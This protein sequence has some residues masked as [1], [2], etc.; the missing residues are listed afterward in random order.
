MDKAIASNLRDQ[1]QRAQ[2]RQEHG[3]ETPAKETTLTN[4]S[5]VGL[6]LKRSDPRKGRIYFRNRFGEGKFRAF[7]HQHGQVKLAGRM[8][9]WGRCRTTTVFRDEQ[10]DVV[11]PEE[12]EFGFHGKRPARLHEAGVRPRLYKLGRGDG[13]DH[14]AGAEAAPEGVKL[15]DAGREEHGVRML[16]EPCGSSG[17]IGDGNP[18]VLRFW[19][20]RRTFQPQQR[21]VRFPGSVA[22]VPG[23]LLGKG[24][25]RVHKQRDIFLLKKTDK[26]IRPS[27]TAKPK[28]S[29]GSARVGGGS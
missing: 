7:G 23:D 19:S 5:G 15:A 4:G 21:D 18:A 29:C 26:A 17:K 1:A 27:K 11:I 12:L 14:K 25:G 13:A 8:E 16:P 28:F 6:R 22:G 20:P 2:I 10:R 9:F 3:T 24:M